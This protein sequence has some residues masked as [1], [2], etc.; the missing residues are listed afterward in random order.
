[1]TQ[2]THGTGRI[3][4]GGG[5][6]HAPRRPREQSAHSTR[7][8]RAHA[9]RGAQRWNP[10]RPGAARRAI[11]PISVSRPRPTCAAHLTPPTAC[12]LHAAPCPSLDPPPLFPT[13]L[14]WSLVLPTLLLLLD[15]WWTRSTVA[16]REPCP[17]SPRPA[18]LPFRQR[19]VLPCSVAARAI[20]APPP[21]AVPAADPRHAHGTAAATP[22]NCQCS[23]LCCTC[24]LDTPLRH[25]L[26]GN[27]LCAATPGERRTISGAHR[28]SLSL[29]TSLRA[30]AQPARRVGRQAWSRDGGGKGGRSP[31]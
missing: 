13:L 3:G 17:G 1:M 30:V 5:A 26:S 22:P 15:R 31:L 11:T 21:Q 10:P 19:P 9:L 12:D 16:H 14:P 6:P 8:R 23:I 29:S 18:P 28:A 4:E 7:W 25:R 20:P 2:T 27:R 24:L